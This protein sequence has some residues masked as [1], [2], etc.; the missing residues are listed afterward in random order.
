MNRAPSALLLVAAL[1]WL[2]PTS[3]AQVDW[4]QEFLN[5]SIQSGQ[6]TWIAYANGSFY[7]GVTGDTDSGVISTGRGSYELGNGSYVITPDGTPI[8]CDQNVAEC[9][10]QLEEAANTPDPP[11]PPAVEEPPA[12]T[13]PSNEKPKETQ[14]A[15]IVYFL[16]FEVQRD[17]SV[18]YDH[19]ARSTGGAW[20][21]LMAHPWDFHKRGR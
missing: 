7:V 6:E 12:E 1:L 10:E 2:A 15:E 9:R 13:P 11:N 5:S 20:G 16:Q 8:D 19:S 18:R 4:Y 17:G 14:G 3:T 21:S